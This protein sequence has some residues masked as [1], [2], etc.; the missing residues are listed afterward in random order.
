[1]VEPIVKIQILMFISTFCLSFRANYK[2]SIRENF[3]TSILYGLYVSTGIAGVYSFISGILS[4]TIT[5]IPVKWQT[6]ILKQ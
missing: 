5:Q 4:H 1:M 2:E 6:L 3:V